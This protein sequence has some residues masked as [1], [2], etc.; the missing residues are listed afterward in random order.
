MLKLVNFLLISLLSFNLLAQDVI[1]SDSGLLIKNRADPWVYRAAADSYYFTASVPEFDRI[2][3][4]HSSSIKGLAEAAP[5]VIWRKKDKGPMSA[6]IWA[7]ELHR[8]DGA[9]YIYFAAG[10]ADQAFH[11]RTYV[12]KNSSADP[13]QGEWQELG[14]LNTGWD[15]FN[16]DATHFEH[17]G[18]HYLVWAQQDK[19]KSYNSALWIAKMRSATELELPA[20]LLTEPTLDWERLGYKVNEGAAVLIKHNKIW[21]AYSASATDHRYAMGLLSAS[22]DADLLK[23]ASWSKAPKPV[24]YTNDSLK[25]FGPGHNS[26]VLAE[27]GVTDLMLYHARDYKEIQGNPLQDGNRHT[28]VRPLYWTDK[29]ELD[30]AQDKPD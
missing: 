6:N 26:F 13:L 9:W 3:L 1:K 19:N 17:Q 25:R 20:T 22:T 8:I 11:I 21:L 2:E 28:R 14:P 29:G 4:R 27:D 24:F 30:F 18:Q 15:S 12:L 7:P 23:T 10:Q 5:K 16:L